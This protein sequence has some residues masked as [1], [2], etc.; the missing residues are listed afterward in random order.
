MVVF[1]YALII[2]PRALGEIKGIYMET[3]DPF[4][5]KFELDCMWT[6]GATYAVGAFSYVVVM[7]ILVLIWDQSSRYIGIIPAT[8]LLVLI[9]I[10]FKLYYNKQMPINAMKAYEKNIEDGYLN[11]SDPLPDTDGRIRKIY[12][13][14]TH[15]E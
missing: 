13:K 2:V 7:P 15:K 14:I 6:H 5:G 8:L 11:E 12:K 4:Y 9:L 10:P 3:P 1:V